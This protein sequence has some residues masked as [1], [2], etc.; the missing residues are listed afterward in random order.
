MALNEEYFRRCP[1]CGTE[2]PP[3]ATQCTGCGTL[4]LGVDLSLRQA[5][6]PQEAP[7]QTSVA[8]KLRCPHADCGAE[9]PPGS[10]RCLYCDRPLGVTTAVPHA[11]HFIPPEPTF[12]GAVPPAPSFYRLPA[13]L[14]DKFRIV[15][16]LPAGGA[17]A[18]IMILAGITSGVKV[19]AK[20]YRPG[21]VPKS[22]V[23]ERVSR[24]GFR[25]V[26]HLIAFGVSDG[27][28][29]EV[30]EYCPAGSLRTLMTGEL[31]PRDQLRMILD[32]L[33]TALA[34]LHELKVI[35]RDLKPEN[36]L[37]R[38]REPLDLVLT[39]FGIASVNDAT[40]RFTGLARTVRYGAPETLSGVL[41]P[42]AD[43]WSLGLILVELLTGHHPFDDL[44]D[45]VITHRLVTGQ[46]DLATLDAPDWRTLCR[47][48]LLR[49]PQQR[50]GMAEIRRWLD[51][52]A[53]LAAPQDDAP[54]APAGPSRPYRIEDIVCRTPVELAAALA[55]HWQA[56]CKDLMRGQL[57]AW[58]GQE[59][60][61]DN[62][63][64]T[65]HDLL[66]L[67]DVSDDLR[68]LRLILHIAPDIP[69]TWR[70]ESLALANL[71]A[72]AAWAEQGD[73]AAA[74][75]LA[76]VFTQKVLRELSPARHPAETA[77]VTCWEIARERFAV[78]WRETEVAR[79]RWRK[80]QTSHGGLGGEAD[81][82]ALVFGQPEVLAPPAPAKLYPALLL[83]LADE[84]YATQQLARVKVEASPYRALSPWL[85]PLLDG[86]D[87]AGW[88]AAGFLLPQARIAAAD[89]QQHQQRT[90]DAVVA[91]SAALVTRSN[92]ALVMLRETSDMGLLAGEFERGATASAAQ[93]VLGLIEEAS[94]AG[95][96]DETPLLRTLRR[97][98][99][100]VLRIQERLDEWEH[101]ARIN[102]LWRN[103]NLLQGTGGFLFF[104]FIATME[105][106]PTRYFA[107]AL[108]L[109]LVVVGWRLWGLAE[110][111]G[112]IRTLGK[113]LPLRVPTT[114]PAEP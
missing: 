80:T 28:G 89:L 11:G 82:D 10:E 96:A 94:V 22:E 92:Q 103:R 63:L 29:Y 3:D 32:E 25:H 8:E 107:L 69:P 76:S 64:R 18:E 24:A 35:H 85:E 68:L 49:D 101:A 60:K 17:E 87:A 52:D 72:Q 45:A 112:S 62:L 105:V 16:V 55:T 97:A 31:L 21:I 86:D 44:S 5:S 39:D 2:A 51:G 4:L 100:V 111:R 40:Q 67:R 77:L 57:S 54:V 71:L 7:P 99:P 108:L 47:G 84:T 41:D 74:E 61:D 59:L 26:V 13:A 91:Q 15:E 36:I 78:L 110:I 34:A 48:L 66:D 14:A 88:V 83:A 12:S 98:E 46:I 23:L 73:A 37:V 113:A 53:T 6:P 56:G 95:I 38:R 43:W 58:V 93:A 1:V 42:A 9:N 30:M 109:P 104:M 50:W 79:T 70:G 90:A 106:L 114:L 19:V 33:A 75:W 81:F 27:I 20:L 65:I 102:A